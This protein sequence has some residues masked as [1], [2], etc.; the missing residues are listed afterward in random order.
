[1]TLRPFDTLM[2]LSTGD[3]QTQCSEPSRGTNLPRGHARR[4]DRLTGLSRVEGRAREVLRRGL[5]PTGSFEG[6]T[7]PS[8]GYSKEA[9]P[10]GGVGEAGF[11]AEPTTVSSGIK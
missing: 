4:F 8:W 11:R 7:P 5:A 10:L 3:G 2:A 9:G 6:G 1:M